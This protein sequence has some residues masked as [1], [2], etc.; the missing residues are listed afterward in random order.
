M[1][2]ADAGWYSPTF[3]KQVIIRVK[4]EQPLAAALGSINTLGVDVP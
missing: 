1:N 2:S 3:S 4:L